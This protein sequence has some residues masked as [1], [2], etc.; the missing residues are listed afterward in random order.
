[1]KNYV[2]KMVVLFVL[3]DI[4]NVKLKKKQN[5]NPQN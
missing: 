5:K 2:M 3:M 1:M 4:Q